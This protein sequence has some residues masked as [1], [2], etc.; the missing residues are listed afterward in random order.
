MVPSLSS[1]FIRGARSPLRTAVR[2]LRE[3]RWRSSVRWPGRVSN[4]SSTLRGHIKRYTGDAIFLCTKVFEIIVKLKGIKRQADVLLFSKAT[5]LKE[6]FHVKQLHPQNLN[7]N[8]EKTLS[9]YF[10]IHRQKYTAV[11]FNT[12]WKEQEGQVQFLIIFKCLYSVSLPVDW[13][14]QTKISP[15]PI[16]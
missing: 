11:Q 4:R 1:S 3:K 7:N 9:C 8:M 2:S 13:G 6:I 16:S 10:N 14:W 15:L 12:W 5:G